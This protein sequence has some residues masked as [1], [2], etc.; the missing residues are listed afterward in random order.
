MLKTYVT[1]S[2]FMFSSAVASYV[3]HPKDMGQ[4]QCAFAKLL[5]DDLFDEPIPRTVANSPT[6]DGIVTSA[7][8]MPVDAPLGAPSGTELKMWDHDSGK[9]IDILAVVSTAKTNEE[10]AGSLDNG[11]CA[12]SRDDCRSVGSHKHF[13][14][15]AFSSARSLPNLIQG[16]VFLPAQPGDPS[17]EPATAALD[18][19][20]NAPRRQYVVGSSSR[21]SPVARPAEAIARRSLVRTACVTP[22]TSSGDLNPRGLAGRADD[23]SVEARDPRQVGQNLQVWAYR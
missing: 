22:L 2:A 14:P 7:R 17:P 3:D 15:R 11:P 5:V 13:T 16:V 18:G 9:Q 8:F 20:S 1:I 19:S 21:L 4:S 23:C 6:N 10:F 12:R